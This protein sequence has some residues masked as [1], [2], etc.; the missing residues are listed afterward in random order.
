VPWGATPR[1]R[2]VWTFRSFSWEA[3]RRTHQC[4]CTEYGFN[5]IERQTTNH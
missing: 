4:T 2:G 5:W 1:G 3:R